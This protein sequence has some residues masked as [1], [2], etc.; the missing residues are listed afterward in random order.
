M[1]E[2]LSVT[3]L[4]PR[5]RNHYGEPWRTGTRGY[6]IVTDDPGYG[7]NDISDRLY[8]GGNLI[9]ESMSKAES[10]RA[11]ECVNFCAGFWFPPDSVYAGG[12]N[13]LVELLARS[14]SRMWDKNGEP[15]W[16][17]YAPDGSPA[18]RVASR[19]AFE[20][21]SNTRRLLARLGR[22]A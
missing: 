21:W 7:H 18:E 16:P 2:N 22:L 20:L 1:P 11:V 4:L 6:G 14:Y 17:R 9:A 19:E 8:S 13:D 12:L 15:R 5:A 10:K 3:R